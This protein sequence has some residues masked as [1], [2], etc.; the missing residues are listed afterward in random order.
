[1]AMPEFLAPTEAEIRSRFL[2]A[3]EDFER[4]TEMKKSTIGLKA[5][6]DANFLFRVEAGADFRIS[7]YTRVMDFMRRT[8]PRDIVPK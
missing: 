4:V 1:M 6:K 8:W 3:V 7:T 2:R 5:L